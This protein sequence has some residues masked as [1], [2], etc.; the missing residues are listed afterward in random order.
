[1]KEN[2]FKSLITVIFVCLFWVSTPCYSQKVQISRPVCDEYTEI[3]TCEV[4]YCDI[5]ITKTI[6]PSGMTSYA[7]ALSNKIKVDPQANNL[8]CI[9]FS[10]VDASYDKR[11][12]GAFLLFTDQT[13]VNLAM[14]FAGNHFNAKLSLAQFN[15]MKSKKI[16]GVRLLESKWDYEVEEADRLLMQE[17]LQLLSKSVTEVCEIQ[18]EEDVAEERRAKEVRAREWIQV[19]KEEKFKNKEVDKEEEQPVFEVVSHLPEFPGGMA[20]CMQFLAKNIRYPTNAKE[21]GTQG[22]VLVQAIINGDGSIVDPKVV[23]SVSSDLDREAIRVVQSMP[24]WNPGVQDGQ[25][26]RVKYTI[27]VMFRLQ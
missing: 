23:R 2:K 25:C 17:K 24:K 7:L 18:T 11:T 21:N 20:A 26:V 3:T 22:R 14:N 15:T 1:M 27:P 8:L 6:T 4:T 19:R 10:D 12:Q 16:K 5:T 13:R 9:P